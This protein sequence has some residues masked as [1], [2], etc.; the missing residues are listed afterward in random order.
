MASRPAALSRA[1]PAAPG[2]EPVAAV[3]LQAA[4]RLQSAWRGHIARD[5]C[6]VG[7]EDMLR[8][9]RLVHAAADRADDLTVSEAIA[10]ARRRQRRRAR[11]AAAAQL[12]AIRI[13][14]AWRGCAVRLHWRNELLEC[15]EC[16]PYP[17]AM[18]LQF[19]RERLADAAAYE[20][21]GAAVAAEAEAA[22]ARVR[23]AARGHLTRGA[24]ARLRALYGGC[25]RSLGLF[26]RRVRGGQHAYDYVLCSRVSRLPPSPAEVLEAHPPEPTP[27]P[28]ASA[29]QAPQGHTLPPASACGAAPELDD[30]QPPRSVPRD[31]GHRSGERASA[32]KAA[33]S[34]GKAARRAAA[35]A[36]RAAAQVARL[37]RAGEVDEWG[38]VLYRRGTAAA[39]VAE[40]AHW[41]A[42][43]E[44]GDDDN[45]NNTIIIGGSLEVDVVPTTDWEDLRAGMADEDHD[46]VDDW[47]GGGDHHAAPAALS[48]DARA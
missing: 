18:L 30:T 23:A 31:R 5:T 48:D 12:L 3:L 42:L 38:G 44:G 28:A 13:Q 27:V 8:V 11:R 14:A 43:L 47:G 16:P 25:A 4:V 39:R 17:L 35:A 37:R 29:N 10:L 15:D 34:A 2:Q 24:L 9:Y 20:A 40:A 46:D 26:A 36:A 6:W 22:S 41:A 19:R 32:A 1:E 7:P 45:N 33:S 21:A